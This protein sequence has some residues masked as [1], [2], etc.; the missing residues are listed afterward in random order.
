[1]NAAIRKA[2]EFL[3]TRVSEIE[4]FKFNWNS[5]GSLPIERIVV[6][7]SRDF[8]SRIYDCCCETRV[9]PTSR[10]TIIFERVIA[11]GERI[12]VEISA[13]NYVF[14]FC[15][16]EGQNEIVYDCAKDVAETFVNCVKR[17]VL[18]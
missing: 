5:R 13:T 8:I 1:M 15:G 9:Y 16:Q 18:K 12:E 7:R 10:G 11:S 14:Y 3:V 2:F 6:D 17:S 4:E